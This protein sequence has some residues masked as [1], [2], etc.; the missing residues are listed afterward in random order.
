ML[1]CPQDILFRN[2]INRNVDD[3]NGYQSLILN[4]SNTLLQGNLTS[5]FQHKDK[6]MRHHLQ[7][8][9]DDSTINTNDS[10]KDKEEVK[11]K[12]NFQQKK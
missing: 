9:I 3:I 1:A 4:S 6:K 5:D 2:E 7:N 12:I 11:E 8:R 10:L